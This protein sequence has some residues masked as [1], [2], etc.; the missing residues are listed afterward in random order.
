MK[1]FL[2]TAWLLVVTLGLGGCGYNTLQS[3]DEQVKAA[4]S[5]VVNQYQRR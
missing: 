5:E 2:V 1:R 4:W 3:S